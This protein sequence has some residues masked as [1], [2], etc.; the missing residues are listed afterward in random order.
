MSRYQ[1][2]GERV[3]P[4]YGL[5]GDVAASREQLDQS[6]QEE[7]PPPDFV[8]PWIPLFGKRLKKLETISPAADVYQNRVN[9]TFRDYWAFGTGRHGGS[10]PSACSH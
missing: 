2:P 4:S 3:A 5:H 6:E 9:Q 7:R 1:E 10:G 8:N